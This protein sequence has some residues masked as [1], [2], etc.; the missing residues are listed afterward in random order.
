M[1]ILTL[2]QKKARQS[3]KFLFRLIALYR[4]QTARFVACMASCILVLWLISCSGPTLNEYIEQEPVSTPSGQNDSFSSDTSA[5]NDATVDDDSSSPSN[6]N[7][8]VDSIPSTSTPVDTPIAGRPTPMQPQRP[9]SDPAPLGAAVA[10]VNISSLALR[11]FPLDDAPTIGAIREGQEYSVSALSRDGKWVRLETPIEVG[12]R[13]WVAARFVSVFGE[14]TGIL[15]TDGLELGYNNVALADDQAVANTGQRRLRIR[16]GP[17][18]ASE[19]VFF[20]FNG[21]LFTVVEESEDGEWVHLSNPSM[22]VDGWAARQF[23]RLASDPIP[24]ARPSPTSTPTVLLS[25]PTARPTIVLPTS[26]PD[27]AS[28]PGLTGTTSITSTASTE[29]DAT[30]AGSIS[31]DASATPSAPFEPTVIG[32]STVSIPISSVTPGEQITIVT[33]G[34]RLRVRSEPT[35]DSEIVARVLNGERYTVIE[36]TEDGLWAKIDIN[37]ESSGWVSTRFTRAA[38]EV[39]P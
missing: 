36:L 22:D 5:N 9:T 39:E 35:T 37:D 31:V 38:T 8:A 15:I 17:S 32:T 6:A 20:A 24:T 29:G 1:F 26:T 27:L 2:I 18:S 23:L 30:P 4:T 28:T 19:T 14:I 3:L 25:P 7:A 33:D 34:S 12:G 16:S 11:R 13:G 21:E 10:K